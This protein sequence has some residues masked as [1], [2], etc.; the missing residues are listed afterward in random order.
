MS[1]LDQRPD[2]L[3]LD[4]ALAFELVEASAV[5]TISHRLILEI[6]LASLVTNGTVQRVVGK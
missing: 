4:C 1:Y 2:V 5:R 3:V 6:T